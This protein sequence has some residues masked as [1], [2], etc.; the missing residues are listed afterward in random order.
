[1][2][3]N[4]FERELP[5]GYRLVKTIDAKD[6]KLGV[7]FSLL[8]VVIF[9]AVFILAF[10][11]M[12]INTKKIE[13]IKDG[14]IF[15]GFVG[16]FVYLVLHELVHGIVYKIK[17]GEKL[18]FGISWS[19]AYCGV[20]KIFTYRKT[21]LCAILAP[22]VIFTVIFIPSLI[23][24]YFYNPSLYVA[25]LFV[26]GMHLGGCVG[27][28][29]LAIL[30]F[31]KYKDN[32]ILMNDTGPKATIFIYD[33]SC[34]DNDEKT[35]EFIEEFNSVKEKAPIDEK[36][37]ATKSKSLSVVCI[38]LFSLFL[39][40]HSLIAFSKNGMLYPFDE[41][42]FYESMSFYVCLFS[43]AVIVIT[44][45][46]VK[47][48]YKTKLAIIILLALLGM[49]ITLISAMQS[50]FDAK[51][52]TNDVTNYGIYDSEYMMDDHF[53]ENITAEMT[54]VYYSYYY[55]N[56]W[57]YC[58]ELYLEVKM[59]D[60]EYKRLKTQYENELKNCFFAPDYKEYVI[61]DYPHNYINEDGSCYMDSPDIRK[62]I[63]NDVE[64]T[65]IFVS[66]CGI[67]PF[68]Y[69]NSY[70]FKRFNLDP[71]EYSNYLEENQQ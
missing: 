44:S 21:A 65:I 27:D 64:Q 19:C 13:A 39:L 61:S 37:L 26:F 5:K 63:F 54:P 62:I 36:A 49:P 52:Y 18:T 15:I 57:D 10:I 68:Y 11:P 51:S 46:T 31:T 29:Y 23:L 1:M 7:I 38:V 40:F 70:Y 59:S 45:L 6:K 24:T 34:L 33:P 56:S 69:E 28:M 48:L 9:F 14:S 41:L 60:N 47:K 43:I 4:N 42:K 35:I 67:D 17:T 3:E 12:V 53:P 8:A 22:L 55:D 50:D 66:I 32:T 16:T 58:Y 25:L 20:P 71:I 2:K 30:L